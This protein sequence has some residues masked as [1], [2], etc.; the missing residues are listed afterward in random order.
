VLST[1]TAP[2]ARDDPRRAEV[3]RIRRAYARYASDSAELKRRDPTNGCL[4]QIKTEMR[5]RLLDALQRHRVDLAGARILDIGCGG[6]ELLEW[7][8]NAGVPPANCAGVDLLPERAAL[9][10]ARLPDAQIATAEASSLEFE[11]RSFDVVS[12]SMVISSV[13]DPDL[14]R[15]ICEEAMRVVRPEGAVVWYDTRQPNPFNKDV[16]AVR[17][18]EVRELFPDLR[19]ELE[20]ITLLPPLARALGRRASRWYGPLSH[21]PFLK[22]RYFGLLTT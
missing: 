15:D 8:V 6:G 2:R 18:R 1:K 10:R 3:A 14:A 5:A 7:F 16:R 11:D 9:A 12:L 21:I 4:V 13:R 22:S 17:L 19:V 20:R